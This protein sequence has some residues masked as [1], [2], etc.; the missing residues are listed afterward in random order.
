MMTACAVAYRATCDF[1]LFCTVYQN[2][3]KKNNFSSLTFQMFVRSFMLT[4]QHT[5]LLL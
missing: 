2:F 5:F 3:A 4:L 1:Y